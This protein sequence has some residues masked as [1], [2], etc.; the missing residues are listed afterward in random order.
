MNEFKTYHPIVNFTY[1]ILVI[2][3]T[4]LIMHPICLG[5]SVFSSY[6]YLTILKD[7]KV[8]GNNFIYMLI[9]FILM[10]AINPLFNHEGVTIIQYFPNGSPLTMESIIYGMCAAA[11]IVSVIGYFS[12][13]NEIMTSDKFIY[14]FGRILPKFSI[15]ISMTLRFVPK[16]IKQLR[17]VSNAQK[18]IGRD[19]QNGS[20]AKRCKVAFGVLSSMTSWCLENAI[21]TADSMKARGYG[22]KGRTS[23]SIYTFDKRDIQALLFLIISGIYVIVGFLTD[24]LSFAF[25]PEISSLN[26]S[27]YTLSLFVSYFILCLSPVIIE[28]W[29]VIKWK[30]LSSKN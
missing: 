3:L 16:Y 18:C 23:F 12:I 30:L 13:Y 26:I 28:L 17:S 5:I 14:L 19:I 4:C 25:F 7:K 11:M 21:E 10:A 2:A 27:P 29:E 6:T 24:N 15:I 8:I 20:I 22:H 1:F 9:T